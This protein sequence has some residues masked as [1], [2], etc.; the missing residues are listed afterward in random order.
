MKKFDKNMIGIAEK[1]AHKSNMRYQICALVVCKK[2]IVSVGY[3]K[4][5]SMIPEFT[6]NGTG[7][8]YSVH[9]ELDA[10][11]K[12]LKVY[13]EFRNGEF[14]LKLYIARR[15]FRLAKPCHKCIKVLKN[16]P[17]HSVIYTDVNDTISEMII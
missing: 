4:F 6:F 7:K 16:S 12:A 15:G 13:P 5:L 8:V 2:T 1:I 14:D 10:L 17:I 3:N 11:N 9:A